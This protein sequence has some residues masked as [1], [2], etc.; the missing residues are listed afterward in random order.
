MLKTQGIV[1]QPI[2]NVIKNP[3][4]QKKQEEHKDST[5]KLMESEKFKKL[6][7]SRD[8]MDV[9]SANLMIQNMVRENDR[10]LQN[11]N[12][13]L[14][15]VQR[16]YES[17]TLLND[18]LTQYSVNELSEDTISTLK[19]IYENCEKMKPTISRMADE[20]SNEQLLNEV[21][22]A[23][24]SLNSALDKY[25]SLVVRKEDLPA[26]EPKV[27]RNL[28]DVESSRSDKSSHA[29]NMDELEEI[30]ANPSKPSKP[31][32]F[33]IADIL[34]PQMMEE[35]NSKIIPI[36]IKSLIQ[37]SPVKTAPQTSDFD[38]LSDFELGNSSMKG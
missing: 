19:E 10:K 1:H 21:L 28:L 20:T 2:Q 17:S 37:K 30:F 33:D 14:M 16:A 12:R 24:D 4:N 7:Q 34:A 15:E 31:L 32:D 6:L 8:P 11:Q 23:S 36:D 22:K 18:M 3:A 9:Q 38:L 35:I 29:N 27:A 13:R 25:Q 5:L 26:S